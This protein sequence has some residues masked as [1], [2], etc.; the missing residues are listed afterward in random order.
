LSD[1]R[2]DRFTSFAD[3]G[4]TNFSDQSVAPPFRLSWVRRYEGTTKHFSVCGGGRMYTHTAEGMIFAVEQ[5]T[6]RLLWRRYFPGVHISYTSPVYYDGRLLVPQAGLDACRLRCFEA[7]TGKL[8]WEAPFAGSPSWNRQQ[9]PIVFKN[10]AFYAFGTGKYEGAAPPNERVSWLF[11]H[12]NVPGFPAS[13]RPI[14]RAY[15]LA[16]GKEAWTR[17]FADYGCGGDEAGL[18]LMDGRLYYSA[19]FGRAPKLAGRGPGP[20]GI[21]AAIEPET[22]KVIWLTAKYSIHGGCTISAKDGRLYLGGYNPLAGTEGRHVWCLRASDGTLMWQSEPLIE[23]IRVATIGPNAVFIHA[24]YQKGYLLDKD[25]GKILA[26][27][28]RHYKCSQFTWAGSCLLGP[29]LDV[30]DLSDLQRVKLL[31]SGPRMDPSECTG[32]FISNGRIY[33]TGG[34]AGLQACTLCG[35]EAAKTTPILFRPGDSAR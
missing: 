13:H 15:D 31:S 27:T 16:T 29:A 18:C 34:G 30:L 24:Q 35:D 14:L 7:A 20:N 32:A 21:T 4:N 26:T 10:L 12:Q 33:Y 25:T 19:Y 17:D 28:A 3:F 9:P 11:G 1:A 5:E 22:G 6:G 23:A 8:L 2:Y